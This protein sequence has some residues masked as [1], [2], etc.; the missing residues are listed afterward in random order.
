MKKE[1]D[2]IHTNVDHHISIDSTLVPKLDSL[3][4]ELDS[5]VNP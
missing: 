2:P 4:H 1:P 3:L 5:V